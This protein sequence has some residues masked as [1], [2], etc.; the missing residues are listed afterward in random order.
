MDEHFGQ[1]EENNLPIQTQTPPAGGFMS[2][3]EDD[4]AHPF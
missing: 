1:Q 4:A 2:Y 3:S